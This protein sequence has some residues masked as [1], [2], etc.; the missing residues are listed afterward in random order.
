M[1]RIVNSN[2]SG[3]LWAICYLTERSDLN[4]MKIQDFSG[5]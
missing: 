3:Q 4:I 5:R 1:G 2:D